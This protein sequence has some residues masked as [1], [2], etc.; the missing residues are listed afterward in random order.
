MAAIT[1]LTRRRNSLTARVSSLTPQTLVLL[2]SGRDPH[3]FSGKKVVR[4]YTGT[5]TAIDSSGNQAVAVVE[6]WVDK[7]AK[8]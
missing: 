7:K 4:V 6:V 5:I 3:P 1:C 8:K 2:T